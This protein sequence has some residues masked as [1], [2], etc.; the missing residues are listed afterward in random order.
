MKFEE[1]WPGV[2]EEKSLKG[3]D[4]WTDD[5]RGVIT[6]AQP[7]PL[8]QLAKSR[9]KFLVRYCQADLYVFIWNKTPSN[10]IKIAAIVLEIS[11]TWPTKHNRY[12]SPE[13]F[14]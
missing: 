10:V 11:D 2:S 4:G 9:K 14:S 6:K 8:A 5:G 13:H 7:A 3:V 1:S 12:S